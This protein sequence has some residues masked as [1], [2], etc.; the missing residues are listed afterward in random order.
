MLPIFESLLPVFIL[1]AI[2]AFLK[3]I[4]LI[5]DDQ[6]MGMERTSYFVFFP[7]LLINTL[8]RTDFSAIAASTSVLSFF[9]GLSAIIFLGFALKRPMQAIFG[10]SSA[11]YSSIFQGFTR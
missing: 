9:G 8:Y 2:G 7:A 11:S 4:K 1:I 6:W 3:Y 10:L 5:A